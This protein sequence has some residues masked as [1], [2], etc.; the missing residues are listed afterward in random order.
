MLLPLPAGA[1]AS[2]LPPRPLSAQ[3]RKENAAATV[4][5]SRARGLRARNERSRLIAERVNAATKMQSAA[6]AKEARDERARRQR[7]VDENK[8]AT[9]MQ[10]AA[11]AKTARGERARRQRVVDENGAALT[12]QRFARGHLTRKLW[13]K[14]MA[15][16][17]QAQAAAKGL[18]MRERFQLMLRLRKPYKKFLKPNEMVLL[19]GASTPPSPRLASLP[20]FGCLCCSRQVLMPPPSPPTLGARAGVVKRLDMGFLGLGFGQKGRH[21]LIFTS[22]PRLLCF[23]QVLLPPSPSPQRPFGCL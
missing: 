15:A 23:D 21:Q 5:A 9:R 12:I 17:I 7:V 14:I 11:R 19:A 16:T 1:C 2:P 6:R 3:E 18:A 13:G 22:Y 4:V 10:S 8:A 20:P